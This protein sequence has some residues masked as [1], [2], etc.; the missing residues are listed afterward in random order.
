MLIFEI[1]LFF[2]LFNFFHVIQQHI[3][4]IKENIYHRN[5]T[6]VVH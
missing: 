2:T 3:L 4:L 5:N 1:C 6:V